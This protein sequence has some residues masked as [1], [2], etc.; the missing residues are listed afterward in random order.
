MI[1]EYLAVFTRN[2]NATSLRTQTIL[3]NRAKTPAELDELIDLR[4]YWV[5]A[6]GFHPAVRIPGS[7][8]SWELW[9]PPVVR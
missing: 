3:L 2:P 7:R 8:I 9:I 1:P 5:W 6:H 4:P